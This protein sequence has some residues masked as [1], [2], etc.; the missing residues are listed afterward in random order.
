MKECNIFFGG[1][2]AK[3]TDPSYIFSGSQDP[4]P[5]GSMPLQETQVGD[6]S[7]VVCIHRAET[8]VLGAEPDSQAQ[9]RPG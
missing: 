7:R 1:G 9:R 6:P 2:G 4:Q 3:H 5:P 8:G